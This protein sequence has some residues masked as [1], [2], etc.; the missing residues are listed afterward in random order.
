VIST[1]SGDTCPWQPLSSA[2]YSRY[3]VGSNTTGLALPTTVQYRKHTNSVI[4]TASFIVVI[5]AFVRAATATRLGE[6]FAPKFKCQQ[7]GR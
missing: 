2:L 1:I 5:V 3:F 4:S 6:L 7:W